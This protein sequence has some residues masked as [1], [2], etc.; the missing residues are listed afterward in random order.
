MPI[1]LLPAGQQAMLKIFRIALY[2]IGGFFIYMVNLL[3]FTSIPS[4]TV[5]MKLGIMAVFAV[6]GLIFILIAMATSRF[7]TW[8]SPV[9]IAML[10][11]VALNAFVVL[12]FLCMQLSPE[13][14]KSFP[15]F[16]QDFI[17]DYIVGGIT[18][19]VT[20]IAGIILVRSSPKISHP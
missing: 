10:S 4:S 6:I 9:G 13:L 11:G 12:T 18:T 17:S 20:L 1:L 14:L 16:P 8:K 2:A 19:F 7:K 15:D 5:A 3:S